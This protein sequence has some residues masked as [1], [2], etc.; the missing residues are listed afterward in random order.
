MSSTLQ[1]L[2]SSLKSP[3]ELMAA[4]FGPHNKDHSEPKLWIM[5]YH[6]ILPK[7]DPRYFAEEPGMIV[8][9]ETFRQQLQIIKQLMTVMPLDEWLRRKQQSLPL[10]P[11]ACAITFDDGWLDNY[12]YAYPIIQSEQIPITLFAV[13]DMIGTARNF[14]PNRLN[15]LLTNTSPE[16]LSSLHWLKLLL[17]DNTAHNN[18]ES[19]NR[20]QI[21]HIIYQ[22]KDHP[23]SSILRWLDE[24][25]QQFA[26][27]NTD[28]PVLMDWQQLKTMASDSL[29][30]VGSHTCNHFRLRDDL[31]AD[32]LADEITRSKQRLQDELGQAIDLFCYPNGDTCPQAIELIEKHYLAAVTT[33]RGI[34]DF[35][36]INPHQLQR[37]GVH[38]DISNTETRFL[39]R[40]SNWL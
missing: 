2:K 15:Q 36:S 7:S 38:Q 11:R 12:E 4:N 16:Q 10:P 13:A 25:E 22:L 31:P 21:A 17:P 18:Q 39:A 33:H 35:S 1:L 32:T 26:I 3:L 8:E 24:A 28:K 6:R 14:W 27:N 23:D 37:I 40:L 20:E 29:V 5:M 34:N 9:P 19:L 30:T